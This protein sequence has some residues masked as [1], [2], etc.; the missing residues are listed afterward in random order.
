MK[1]KKISV[2][3]CVGCREMKPKNQLVRI[4]KNKENEISIDL[5]GKKSGRGA[6]LC[7]DCD[8]IEKA[9][10]AGRLEKV[11]ESRISEE[12]YK[13]LKENTEKVDE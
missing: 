4:V 12:I 7:S 6:Y 9:K 3:L 2:R 11:F 1:E 13:D 5:T 10:K 8:C